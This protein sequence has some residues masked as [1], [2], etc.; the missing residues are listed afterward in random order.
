MTVQCSCLC[1]INFRSVSDVPLKIR[2]FAI[3]LTDSKATYKLSAHHWTEIGSLDD[4][5]TADGAMN[6]IDADFMMYPNKCYKIMHA[7]KQ[8][9]FGENSELQVSSSHHDIRPCAAINFDLFLFYTLQISRIELMMGTATNFITLTLS[10]SLNSTKDFRHYDR[11][12]DC[13]QNIVSCS[14]CYIVPM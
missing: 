12:A 9:Q 6:P 3:I 10:Q 8:N 4:A 7:A 1:S 5:T 14:T 11:K 2:D 13:L